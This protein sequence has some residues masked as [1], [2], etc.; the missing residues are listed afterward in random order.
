MALP[1]PQ[2]GL[3][4]RYDYL[5][6]HDA[7]A[8]LCEAED[9]LRARPRGSSRISQRLSPDIPSEDYPD[10]PRGIAMTNSC[11]RL[12]ERRGRWLNSTEWVD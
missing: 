7:A 8:G 11:R 5:W 10:G 12:V 3:I 6:T 4:V 9:C 1:D 2:L